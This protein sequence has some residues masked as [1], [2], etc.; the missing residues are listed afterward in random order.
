MYNR[1]SCNLQD[2]KKNSV[3]FTREVYYTYN[4]NNFESTHL[5]N[6]TDLGCRFINENFM[7]LGGLWFYAYYNIYL[8]IHDQLRT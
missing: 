6:K 7:L 1:T 4:L 3:L 5:Q 2:L 8:S